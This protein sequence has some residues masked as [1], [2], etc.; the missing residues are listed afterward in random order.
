MSNDVEGAWPK[1]VKFSSK[2]IG[3]DP[4]NPVYNLAKVEIRPITPPHFIRDAMS[5][6][7]I[8]GARPRKSKVIEII[9]R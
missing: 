3:G 5:I 1:C 2:R 4:L 9:T 7:D 8:D 6:I